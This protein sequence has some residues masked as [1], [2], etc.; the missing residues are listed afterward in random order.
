MDVIRGSGIALWRQ[1][2]ERIETEIASGVLKPGARCPTEHSLAA[3]FGVNRHTVR[4]AIASLEEKG[5]LRV[6]QGR[7]TFVREQVVD[8]PVRKRTRFRDTVAEQRRVPGGRLVHS[9]TMPADPVV[10]EAL[11]LARAARIVLVRNLGE[12]DGQAVGLVDHYFSAARFPNI[13]E[14]YARYQSISKALAEAGIDDYTRKVTRVVARMPDRYEARHLQHPL[15]RPLL[16][17]ESINI[18][19]DGRPIEYGVARFAGDRVQ[20]VFEP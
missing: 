3:Q 9:A 12:V 1:I 17:S 8:Y 13:A 14:A 20:L 18:D 6:E 4:R 11:G 16:I 2:Q 19:A 15:N 10:A 5:L 7:G